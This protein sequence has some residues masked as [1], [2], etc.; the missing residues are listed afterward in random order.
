LVERNKKVRVFRNK[1]MVFDGNL[2]SLKNV[3][4][5]VQVM[6]KDTDCGMGF[7]G[8]KDFK[9]GDLV[10]CYEVIEEKRTL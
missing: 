6:K 1:E 8:W 3:K 10:Q 2:D 4:K 7:D 5:D 9:E